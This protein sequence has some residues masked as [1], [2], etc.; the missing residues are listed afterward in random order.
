MELEG[1]FDRSFKKKIPIYCNKIGIITS[2]TGSVIY[3]I[4]N[5]IKD[6]FPTN[7]DL[8]PVS[9]QGA[10][11]AESIIEAIK[12]FHDDL[13]DSKPDLIIVER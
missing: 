4:I 8:W 2:P 1:I 10:N 6:R 13:Y 5:R 3:D 12:G 11:A 7:I 9:V